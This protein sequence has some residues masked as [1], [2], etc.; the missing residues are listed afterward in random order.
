MSS[1]SFKSHI[2]FIFRCN[3]SSLIQPAYDRLVFM[4]IDGLRAD[5]VIPMPGSAHLPKMKYVSSLIEKKQALSFIAKAK[6]PT[7][8][9]PRIKVRTCINNNVSGF[10][11]LLWTNMI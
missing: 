2:L 9:T 1:L 8:T 5:L 3:S 6:P 10:P 4:V 7:L 11:K